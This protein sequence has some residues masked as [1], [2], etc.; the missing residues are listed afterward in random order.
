M[1]D[2]RQR[3]LEDLRVEALRLAR[4]IHPQGTSSEIVEVAGQFL[5][6]MLNGKDTSNRD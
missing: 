3:E 1:S 5:Q 4:D 2:L 6:F